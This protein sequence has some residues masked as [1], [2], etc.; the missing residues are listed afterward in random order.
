[1]PFI[2]SQF[3]E[4]SR[5]LGALVVLAVHTSNLF[6][7][8]ADIMSAP[9]APLAYV[10]WFYAAFEL[11]HQA[12]LAFFV[13]SGYLVGGAVL[14][15]LRK[16]QDF[17]REYFIHRVSRIYLVVGPA[18]VLTLVL[19]SLGGWLFASSGVYGW[20]LFK[21]HFSALLFLTSFL[22]L[23]GIGFDYFGTNGPLWSLACEFWYYVTFPLLLLPF[24]R[25]YPLALRLLGFALG[26]ALFAAISTPPSWFK[27]G[28]ILW[29]GG[30]F[31][32]LIP[33][34]IISSRWAAL[35]LYAAV[36]VIIR[37]VVRGHLVEEHPWAA[38]AADLLGSA[39]FVIVLIAFRYGPS[40]G[41]SLLRFKFHKTLADFSFSLYS[42]HMPIL[43][44]ARAAVGGTL[45]NDWATQLATPQ[46]YAVAFSVMGVAIVAGY[47]FSRV[48][49]A[50]TG[51]ARR[52]LRAFVDRWAPAPA[53]PAAQP[54]P[55]QQPVAA[56]PP[57]QR[58]EA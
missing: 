7:N 41:F 52:K 25:N 49:E 9:H 54:V 24:A 21:G 17:L 26:A 8:N 15:H 18:V 23:Q 4:A 32:T 2:L 6:I 37:L 36:V 39:L 14:A 40:E 58:I 5:W 34:P 55:E 20:P 44:F 56:Q 3:I 31:A 33:R 43:I 28:Y 10:W 50:K 11:G 16:N 51:A 45:G 38:D 22:N 46:N 1:M 57:R 42:I 13:M 35:L 19:D 48:T 27:F 47:F 29:A 12:V 30:A 53:A